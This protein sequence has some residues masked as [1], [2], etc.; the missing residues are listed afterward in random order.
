MSVQFDLDDE[1]RQFSGRAPLFP[2][3]NVVFY[4]HV[5][6]PLHIFEPRYR[7]MVA[8]ALRDNRYIAMALLQP[9]WESAYNEKAPAIFDTV[10]LGKITAEDR[11]EDG[12]YNLFLRGMSRAKVLEEEPND[13]PYRV[14]QLEVCRDQYHHPPMIDRRNRQHELLSGFR[15]MFPEIDLDH[16]LLQAMEVD[17]PWGGLCDVLADSMELEPADAQ[18]ILEEF[19]VDLRSDLVLDRLRELLKD[20]RTRQRAKRFPPDFSSN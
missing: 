17:I 16:V 3:P 4:P 8:D 2:L 18:K 6:L 12:R 20:T 13:L 7:Q 11:L 1:L 15:E 10:C 14:G 5:L 19:D 9:G